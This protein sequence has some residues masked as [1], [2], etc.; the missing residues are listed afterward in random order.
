MDF[1]D[2]FLEIYRSQMDYTFDEMKSASYLTNTLSLNW[3][4]IVLAH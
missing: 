3:I 4:I 2:F 1:K